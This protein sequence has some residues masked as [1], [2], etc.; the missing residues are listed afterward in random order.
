MKPADIIAFRELYNI[1]RPQFAKLMGVSRRAVDYWEE[2]TSS[3]SAARA[4]KFKEVEQMFSD[5]P[6]TVAN[7]MNS[8]DTPVVESKE[9]ISPEEIIAIRSA[10][11][12]NRRALARRIGASGSAVDNWE[13]GV[14]P[15]SPEFVR[16]IRKLAKPNNVAAPDT[17]RAASVRNTASSEQDRNAGDNVAVDT[18]LTALGHAG[19]FR[20]QRQVLLVRDALEYVVNSSKGTSTQK[21]RDIITT[22]LVLIQDNQ[23]MAVQDILDNLAKL[24]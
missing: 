9:T 18:I 16:R 22:F 4:Q 11:G 13:K 19:E 20:R 21:T 24:K 2:G 12:W 10:R 15:A 7:A 8:E 3:I 5:N 14:H 1:T 17:N 6:T 23:P